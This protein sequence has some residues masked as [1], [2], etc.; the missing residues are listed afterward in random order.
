MSDSES[1]FVDEIVQDELPHHIEP[2]RDDFK[3]WHKV[4]KQFIRER[5]WNRPIKRMVERLRHQLQDEPGDW[6]LDPEVDPNSGE[7]TELPEEIRIERPLKCLLIPGD[8][9]LDVRSLWKEILS[10]HC[11]IKYLGFNEVQ[12]SDQPGT[13]VHVANNEVTSLSRVSHDSQVLPD[14]FQSIASPNSQAY[15]YLRKYGPFDV[16]ILDLCDS[17]FPTIGGDRRDYYNAIHRLA[18]YQMRNQTTPWLLF[19]TTQVEPGVVLASEL[20]RMC[21]PTRKN[22]EDYVGFAERLDA[23]I[24][25]TAFQTSESAIDVSALDEEQLIRVFG[26]AFG[27][28]LMHLAASASPQWFID[29]QPCYR[30]AIR[31]NPRVEMLSLA[32]LFR[33]NFQAPVDTSGLSSLNIAQ[34]SL[35][36]ESDFAI[37]LLGAI[38]RLPNV[39]TLLNSD[40]QL[41]SEMETA[42]A[43]LLESAG[44]D[45]EKYLSWPERFYG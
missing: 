21:I 32:F 23:M 18:E 30:Y 26:V 35:L 28:W 10:K 14:R 12:G 20:E 7:P 39:D 22:R 40:P 25:P 2:P 19:V 29:V 1:D 24:P 17:L 31:D 9:L 11:Y 6:S 36:S 43:D 42:S 45:R 16:V 3:P 13:R 33:P 38:E 34:K 8:D 27:K 4:R 44:Y 15:R 41:R 37:K 5:Q